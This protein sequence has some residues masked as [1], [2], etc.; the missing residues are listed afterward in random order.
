MGIL[1]GVHLKMTPSK[2]FN[3]KVF[4]KISFLILESKALVY[5]DALF[6]C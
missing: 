5:P 1:K 2:S 6:C 4:I 3:L